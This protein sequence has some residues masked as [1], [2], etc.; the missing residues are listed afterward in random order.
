MSII[1]KTLHIFTLEMNIDSDVLAATSSWVKSFSSQISKVKVYATHVGRTDKIENVEIYEIGGGSIKSKVKAFYRLIKI[2]RLINRNSIVFY[3]MA[4][5]PAAL[6]GLLFKLKG[7]KQGLWYSHSRA[8][9]HLFPATVFV[10]EIFSSTKNSFPIQTKKLNAIGHGLTTPSSN[11]V[12]EERIGKIMV[13]RLAKVKNIEKAIY[14]ISNSEDLNKHLFLL[15]NE[16]VDPAYTQNLIEISSNTRVDLHLL[17]SQNYTA[18]LSKLEE[19]SILVSCTPESVDKVVIEA[20]MRG[21]LIAT[22]NSSALEL[23][24]MLDVWKQFLR[25]PAPDLTD[26]LSI[27]SRIDTEEIREMRKYIAKYTIKTSDIS[28]TTHKILVKLSE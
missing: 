27:L 4:S 12:F 19:T 16:K 8:P 5:K 7:V 23:T 11:L 25:M 9:L 3:H 21:N 6:L 20:A 17:G 13:G 15:G 28:N 14:S 2:A 22:E 1:D 24:G 18:V 10:N 26:Q